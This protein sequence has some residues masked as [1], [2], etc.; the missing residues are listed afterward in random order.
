LVTGK[1]VENVAVKLL[2]LAVT[3]LPQDVKAALRR[4]YSEEENEV[5]KAQLKAIL[6]NVELAEKTGA[7]MCQDTG[8]II[9]YVKA[10]SQVSELDKVED[11][12]RKA[13]ARATIEVP[14][15][16]RR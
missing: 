14:L 16:Q 2:K 8:V 9:F 1:D 11:A 10:G 4:A 6:D 15:R 7:P 5:G 13:T 3:E 12:L